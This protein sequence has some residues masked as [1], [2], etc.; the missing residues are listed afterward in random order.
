MTSLPRKSLF[1]LAI[2]LTAFV[3]LPTPDAVAVTVGS[4]FDPADF[5]PLGTLNINSGTIT[6]NTST[7]TV[8]GFGNGVNSTTQGGEPVTV[9]CFNSIS[10]TGTAN[11]VVT[12]NRAIVLLSRGN[13]TL[14]RPMNIIGANASGQ[15]GGNG[16]MGGDDGGDDGQ[17]GNG[18]G[19]GESR[20][21]EGGSGAGYG[22]L[23]GTGASSNNDGQNTYGTTDIYDL[24][25]GSGGGG[26]DNGSNG[27]GGGAGGGAISISAVGTLSIQAGGSITVTGGNGAADTHAGGGGGSGGSILLSAPTVQNSGTLTS[28]GGN[29]GAA[30]N[31][32]REGGGG[33]GGGRIA[34]YANTLT[35]GTTNVTGGSGGPA[36]TSGGAGASGTVYTTTFS[37]PP[38]VTSIN[39]L[40]TNPTSAASVSFRIVFN[41]SVS[42]VQLSD[43]QLTTTGVTGTSITGLSGSGT[44]YDVTVNTGAG[45][46]TIRLDVIDLDTIVNSFSQPLGGIGAGNGSFTTGQVYTIDR[47]PPTISISGPSVANTDN[48]PV[49]Y[50]ITYGGANAVTLANANVTLITTGT[51]TGTRNVTGTGTTTRTVTI[52]GITG[53]GTIGISIAA[54]TATDSA[55]NSA[56]A[57]GPSTT[58]NVDNVD[59]TISISAPSVSSTVNGPVT[60]TITYTGADSISLGTGDINLNTTGFIFGSISVSGTGT[61]TRTVTISGITGLSG[62]MGISIDP[63]TASDLAG[64]TAPAAGPSATFSVNATAV[65]ISISAP[66]VTTTRTGPVTYTITYTNASSVS[67]NTGNITLNTTGTATGTVAVSGTGSTTRTVTISGISGTGTLGISIAANTGSNFFSSAPAAGPS[68]TFNVDNTPPTVAISAPSASATTSGPIT[69]TLTYTGA[70]TVTLVPANISLNSTGGA[71][72]IVSV[73]GTGTATRTVTISSITGNGTLG[74]NVNANTASDLAGNFAAAAGPSTTFIVDNLPPTLSIGAPSPNLTNTG[75]VTYTINYTDADAVTLTNSDITLNSTGTAFGV[76]TVSGTGTATRTVTISSISGDGTLGISIAAGTASDAAGNLSAAA[77]PSAAFTVDNSPP[78]V[79][80]SAPSAP[81]TTSGPITYTVSYTGANAVTLNAADI[82]LNSS[83]TATGSVSVTGTGPSLRTVTINGITGDGSLGISV[84]ALT[85]V[86]VLGNFSVAAGPSAT[87]VVD[88]TA[89]ALSI[90]APSAT[91]TSAGPITY[92]VTYTD[93][94]SILLAP[95][96]ITLDTTGTATGSI[97]VLG[98]GVG[99]RTVEISGIT[100]DGTLGISIASGS[101]ADV[102]GN[103][104]AAAGPSATFTVDN[105]GPTI[106][107]GAPS[108]AVTNSGPVTYSVTYTDAAAVTLGDAD[109]VLS[110][111]GSATGV[112]T[113]SGSGSSRTVTFSSISG[114]GTL[115]FTIASGTATDTAGNASDAAGPSSTFDVDNTGPNLSISAPS[116]PATSGGP[117]SYTV[118]FTDADSVSLNPGDISLNATGTATGT[119]SVTGSGTATRTVT[120]NGIS[121]EGTLG[122]SIA[123]NTALDAVGNPAS[124]AGPSATF[125]VDNT[126]PTLSIGAPSATLTA[127]GPVT[128]TVTYTDADAV[129][130]A[131]G[132]ITLNKTGTADGTVSVFG[133]GHV[134][135]FV[136]IASIVGNGTLGISIGSGTGSDDAG[137]LAGPAGPSATFNVSNVLP[138]VSI[139]APSVSTTATGPVSF[140]L[141]FSNVTAINMTAANVTLNATGTAN[142]VVSVSGTGV[143]SRTVTISSITGDGTLSIS[144]SAGVGQDGLSQLTPAAGPSAAVNVDNTAPAITI[145]A[146]SAASAS[147]GPVS[148]TVNYTGASNVTLSP[149]DVTLNQT[150]TANGVVS[151]TGTGTSVRTVTISGI[152]GDGTLGISIAAATAVDDATNAAPSAGPS[153]TFAVDNAGPSLAIGVP[154]ASITR[155]GPVTF[156]LTYIDA[157][158]ITLSPADITLVKTGTADGI[159]SVSGS[160]STSRTV[161]LLNLTGDGTLRISIAANT[162]VDTLNNFAGAAG[163]SLAVIVDNTAPVITMLGTSPLTVEKTVPYVDAG[164]TALDSHDGNITGAIVV[165]NNVDVWNVGSYTVAYNVTDTAGNAAAA[166]IRTVNVTSQEEEN[167]VLEFL[168]RTICRPGICVKINPNVV[169]TPAGSF[170]LIID[171]PAAGVIPAGLFPSILP[172]T[173]FDVKPYSIHASNLGTITLDYGDALARSAGRAINEQSL[174]VYYIDPETGAIEIIDGTIDTLEKT[175]AVNIQQL[176]V[177]AVGAFA[178]PPSQGDTDQ[179]LLID[180]DESTL[181]TNPLDMDTDDDGVMDGTEVEFGTDPLNPLDFPDLP[182]HSTRGLAALL[183]AMGLMGVMALTP[184][185]R[186]RRVKVKK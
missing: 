75:P 169:F 103:L 5:T 23:G 20:F 28:R 66:S 18:T 109:I 132:D 174:F 42:N 138:S 110:N 55:G 84:A 36:T 31:I 123:A 38:T 68:I 35:V 107:I 113:V 114:N 151:V 82:T 69:Y 133:L 147:T 158:A 170:V 97:N 131:L 26:G 157:I 105:T 29:G 155:S 61:T 53:N 166:K 56:P 182:A 25:G 135:R 52:S 108:V 11:I 162:A 37:T 126:A 129:S 86:D 27:G 57:A 176:G 119:V 125:V 70:D 181:G 88:N 156:N 81:L 130:L 21:N 177:Y 124:A 186:R 3:G 100:G 46:G 45:S 102:A 43:L 39:R 8:T 51:A 33:G 104:S 134:T 60:F 1:T 44:T 17:D 183:V 180:A 80:I 10:I 172:G 15:N 59:P 160:G 175:I 83:G 64:N 40:N 146:P 94:D 144:V 106:A 168:G 95:G 72:G 89:P 150:G 185:V 6:F 78:P 7:R 101:A 91:L 63:G 54:G 120:I 136:T 153:A 148:Y 154:S 178:D 159:V 96:L 87:F 118:S 62:T 12:G 85:A 92:T 49:T 30:T 179:D 128:F 71:T 171:R 173:W 76:A 2:I 142:G 65:G 9:Y 143:V 32:N 47:T 165:T 111:T 19:R 149:G 58:F 14:A 13:F 121:G 140:P 34:I 164:A 4:R 90:S 137:N 139:G 115:G 152:T 16:A 74:I 163:P 48:G 98:S 79:V 41:Q 24:F 145:S 112:A 184:V 93:A 77:G 67:L 116:S 22:G 167:T 122:I 117:I 127:V 141:T 161:S 73:S 99:S 50:T